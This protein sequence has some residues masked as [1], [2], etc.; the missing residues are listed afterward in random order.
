M[1]AEQ[2]QCI[3][4]QYPGAVEGQFSISNFLKDPGYDK[5]KGLVTLWFPHGGMYARVPAQ[6]PGNPGSETDA[7]A[8]GG[9][10]HV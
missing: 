2:R 1:V 8:G 4:F 5:D 6:L 10:G 3:T 9:G 7:A